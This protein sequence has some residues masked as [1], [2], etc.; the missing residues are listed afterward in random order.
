[1]AYFVQMK[2][3]KQYFKNS[4]GIYNRW[5]TIILTPALAD[6]QF[7]NGKKAGI[8]VR[9]LLRMILLH[10]IVDISIIATAWIL[11][12]GLLWF[13][14]EIA[15]KIPHSAKGMPNLFFL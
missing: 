4:V 15:L 3:I 12:S 5:S 10:V 9:E 14:S 1:M 11:F 2:A 13:V 7:R 8:M 6:V